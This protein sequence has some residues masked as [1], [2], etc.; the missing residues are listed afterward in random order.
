MY[1]AFKTNLLIILVV[2]PFI[3]VLIP[4]NCLPQEIKAVRINSSLT[5]DGVFDEDE[6]KQAECITDFI[7]FKPVYGAPESFK[8]MVKILYTNRMIYFGIDCKDPEPERITAITTKRDGFFMRED[9]TVLLLDTFHDKSNCYYFGVN[10]L[11]TQ[12]DGKLADNGGTDDIRWDGSW[13]SACSINSDGW[14]CEIAIPFETIKFNAKDAIWGFNVERRIA[15]NVERSFWIGNLTNPD[16]VSQFGRM[17]NLDLRD[18]SVKRYTIIPYGQSRFQKN[19]KPEEK[20]GVDIRYS[21]SRNLGIEATVNPDFATI[22]AD[23]EQVNLTRFELSYPEKRPFF[24]EGTEN[25]STRLEQFYSRRI[26]EIPWGAKMTGKIHNW[27]VN[28]LTTQSDPSSAGADVQKGNDAFYSVF[29]INR[30]IRQGSNIGVIGANRMYLGKNSGSIGLV[31][32]LFFTDVLG[33]TSQVVKSYGEADEG[34]WTY[35]LRPSYDSQFSHFHVRYS[36]FGEGVMENMNGIGFI[37]DDDRREFDTSINR[38]FWIN[39]YGIEDIVPKINY[40]RYWS[41]SGVLRSWEGQNELSVNFL[42]KWEYQLNYSEEFKRYEKDFRNRLVTNELQYDNKSGESL[43]FG[44][45]KGKNYDRDIEKITGSIDVKIFEG[46]DLKY[47]FTR[48]WFHPAETDDNS[49]I[50][51]VRTTYYVN[52]DLYFKVFY[53]TKHR[54]SHGFTDP[55]LDLLRKTLQVVFVWRIVPPFGSVQLAYQDGTSV[56][57]DVEDQGKTLFS[58]VSWVF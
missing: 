47:Y 46:W 25:Y 5:I 14:T 17:S 35:F 26:G 13:E 50:H 43:S 16:R 2:I 36:H 53:Q 29:R 41:Q 3:I 42:K 30:E 27:S 24:L 22:E 7:Q 56:Y 4:R 8:T 18:L 21:L 15:R 31:S 10:P 32:T 6:W 55:E 33:I 19:E 54:F 40:N 37:R 9:A 57:T 45:S 34:T 58:K 12:Q 52:K 48:H 1:S 44:F 38:N 11:G 39:K 23:V 20:F 51:Y 49:W 28:A